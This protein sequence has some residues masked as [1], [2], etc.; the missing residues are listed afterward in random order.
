MIELCHMDVC[1]FVIIEC[2]HL[3]N[4]RTIKCGCISLMLFHYLPCLS[5]IICDIIP[6]GFLSVYVR[7]VCDALVA[8]CATATGRP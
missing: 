4:C 5:A 8:S 7:R 3:A 6:K 2:S 1:H